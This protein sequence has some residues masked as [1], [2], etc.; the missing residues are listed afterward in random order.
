MSDFRIQFTVQ[1]TDASGAAAVACGGV[2][3]A[4]VPVPLWPVPAIPPAGDTAPAQAAE[5]VCRILPK[6]KKALFARKG[7]DTI[8][9]KCYTIL[10]RSDLA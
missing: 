6:K 1:K 2:F 4:A 7:V 9:F 3:R 5:G 10:E 8:S